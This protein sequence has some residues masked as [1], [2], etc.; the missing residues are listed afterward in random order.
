MSLVL[1]LL[2]F[3]FGY[4][5]TG[6]PLKATA[7]LIVGL[8]YTMAFATATVGHLNILTITFVPML[9]GLAIDFGVHLI[10]RFEEELRHGRSETVAMTKAMVFTGKGIFTG[11][12]T[13]AGAFLAMSLTNFRGIREMGIICG[14]GLVISLFPMLTMLPALLL[15]RPGRQNLIE[16][17]E[18]LRAEPDTVSSFSEAT[19]PTDF[20]ARLERLWL[21]RPWTVLGLAAVL[22]GLSLVGLRWTR[23]DYNL[24]NMQ[25]PALRSVE[26]EHKLLNSSERSVIFAAVVATNLAQA[27][28]LEARLH[29]LPSVASVESMAQFLSPDVTGKLEQI[30]AIGVTTAP[31][32]FREPDLR[33]VDLNDLSQTLWSLQGYLALASDE[34]AKRGKTNL[35]ADLTSLRAALGDLRT[36]MFR[37]SPAE[38]EE[39]ARKLAGFQQAL[40]QDLRDTIGTL[41]NQ[42]ATSGLR[43][44]DLPEA[45]RNRFVGIDGRLLLQVYPRGDVWD[46]APQEA[47]IR[48]LQSVDPATTGAPVQMYYYTELLKQSYVEAAG[49]ALAATVLLVGLHFRR[50]S[51][52]LLS[53]LPVGLGTLWVMGLMGW[54]GIMFNPANV[55]MLP[56]VIGIGITNGIHILNRFAEEKNPGILAKSTGKAVLVSGLTTIAGFGSLLIA[57]HQGIRSLG[58]VMAL[59]TATCM[60]AGLTVLPALLTLMERR[61]TA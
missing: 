46:R 36:A 16:E 54:T 19:A 37:G 43:P 50:V 20:R 51:S 10:T 34:V 61:K 41:Q 6:R 12:L 22:S 55:M 18:A 9:I 52:I 2:I 7:C 32:R 28:E 57:D 29:A 14:G 11:C 3:I 1:V 30:R 60:F 13:T 27:T 44:A 49:W 42:D 33:P 56:L 26:F 48:D 53:L 8:S 38:Q 24:L 47:F 17:I 59:G 58:L 35:L 5:Q 40:L 25:S 39:R 45:L 31:L 15:R 21:D 4:Q 23:F